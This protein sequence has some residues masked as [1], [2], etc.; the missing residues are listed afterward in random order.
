M[1]AV[2][3]ILVLLRFGA[4][5]L[6][7][8][9]GSP[10]MNEISRSNVF[11]LLSASQRL[12][13]RLE[14]ENSLLRGSVVDLMLKIQALRDAFGHPQSEIQPTKQTPPISG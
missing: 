6:L 4:F 11:S 3:A 9:D 1:L 5:N 13:E 10:R 8:T 2:P 14:A 7:S 12:L